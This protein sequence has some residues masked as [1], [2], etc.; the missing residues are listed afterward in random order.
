MPTVFD[1]RSS[2]P[3]FPVWEHTC[4]TMTFANGATAAQH[5][6]IPINGIVKQVIAT[7]AHVTDGRTF[8][9]TIADAAGNTLYSVA[10]LDDNATSI[11]Y[12][13]T[14]F[15]EGQCASNGFI[16]TVTPSGAIGASTATAIVTL[17]GL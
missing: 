14:H 4:T 11:K 3:R 5:E 17:R 16:V 1:R 15:A 13:T 9:V 2:S 10:A 6:D 7:F 8:T 12:V